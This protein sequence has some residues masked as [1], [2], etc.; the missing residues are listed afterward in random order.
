MCVW[1]GE[2]CNQTSTQ[3][4]VPELN[5]FRLEQVVFEDHNQQLGFFRILA[6]KSQDRN[7]TRVEKLLI[8]HA[9]YV[10]KNKRIGIQVM[11]AGAR[12]GASSCKFEYS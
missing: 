4:C 12:L 7:G 11:N 5:L 3:V 2:S 1:G 6:V 10:G 9:R 8:S